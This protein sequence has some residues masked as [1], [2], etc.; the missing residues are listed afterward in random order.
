MELAKLAA[1]VPRFSMPA[2]QVRMAME[3]YVEALILCEECASLSF[4]E[5]VTK[6]RNQ[7]LVAIERDAEE[8][9]ALWKDT[10]E[11]NPGKESDQVREYLS[12]C[13]L[14]FKTA[15]TA[16]NHLRMAWS[17]RR[18]DLIPVSNIL[19]HCKRSSDDGAIYS[20][21]RFLLDHAVMTSKNKRKRS[22]QRSRIKSSPRKVVK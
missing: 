12:D 22:R 13:G 14:S 4:E 7:Q 3:L 19:A 5:L 20:I 6:F 15:R 9:E 21:P 16:L 8:K 18:P 11:L 2:D 10:L 1:L 17:T